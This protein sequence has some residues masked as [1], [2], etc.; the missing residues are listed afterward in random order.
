MFHWQ[1]TR[2]LPPEIQIE[3]EML[4]SDLGGNRSAA[5]RQSREAGGEA[6][7]VRGLS[8]GE[9]TAYLS[10]FLPD[11][12]VVRLLRRFLGVPDINDR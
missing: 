2:R 9:P 5:L 7:G 8:R 12:W 4:I 10:R 1:R 11:S 6:C 3:V